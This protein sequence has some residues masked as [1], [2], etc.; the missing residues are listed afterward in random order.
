MFED[1]IPLDVGLCGRNGGYDSENLI[2]ELIQANKVVK[3]SRGIP[4][5]SRKV[6]KGLYKNSLLWSFEPGAPC[7]SIEMLAKQCILALIRV[8]DLF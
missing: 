7:R 1:N 3:R 5:K 2:N 8:S 6:I 4:N